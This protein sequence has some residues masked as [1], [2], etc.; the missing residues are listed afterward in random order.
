VL[1]IGSLL[2][3]AE[4]V[5]EFLLAWELFVPLQ[6]PLKINASADLECQN[7]IGNIDRAIVYS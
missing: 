6:V 7:Q 1:A 3:T 5:I 2:H 4:L